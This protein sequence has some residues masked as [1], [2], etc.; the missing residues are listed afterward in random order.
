[1]KILDSVK[2]TSAFS[3]HNGRHDRPSALPCSCVDL[4]TISHGC[5]QRV[6]LSSVVAFLLLLMRGTDT[7][8]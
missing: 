1:M 7:F 4:K 2:S 6:G 8:L 5:R 3:V